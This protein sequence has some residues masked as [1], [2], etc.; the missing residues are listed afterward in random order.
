MRR[1]AIL[2]AT[3]GA[4][5]V[6]VVLVWRSWTSPPLEDAEELA[7]AVAAAPASAD[8]AVALARP[9]RAARWLTSHP[10]ALVLLK[11]AAPTANKALPRIRGFLVALASEARG[12]F[13]VWWRG[14]ELAVRAEVGPDPAKALQQ[15]AAL[16]GLAFR[17]RP[18]AGGALSVAASSSSALLEQGDPG[19]QPRIGP[20]MLTALARCGGRWWRVRAGRST[21]ELAAGDPLELPASTAIDLIA[22]SDLAALVAAVAPLDWLPSAPALIL[23]DRAGWGVALPTTA[24]SRDLRRLL[25]LG[26]DTA[27][28]RP[29]GTRHWRGLLGDLWALPGPGVAV[30]SRLDLLGK[31]PRE[32][33]VGETG[34]VHGADLARFLKRV[35]DAADG[36]PGSVSYVAAMR[37]G[38]PLLESLRL[39]RWHLLPL[40]GRILL[41]W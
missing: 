3:A 17:A 12:P 22:T 13:C 10:Q 6:A 18:T 16:E 39:A 26:G 36:F 4:L 38:A 37:R 32:G 15:L 11:L 29:P 19:P 8:G 21:L 33:I 9:A 27:I 2:L 30:A 35:A 14:A 20:G 25:T 5:A 40:G 28:E 31:L 7:A 24:I 23:F 34:A 41:E 1:P